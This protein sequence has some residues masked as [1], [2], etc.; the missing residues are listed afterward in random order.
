MSAE[1][2]SLW[3]PWRRILAC[4]V[5]AYVARPLVFL[6]L[7]LHCSSICLCHHVGF[8]LYEDANHSEL[9]PPLM[10]ATLTWVNLQ[11]PFFQIR[12]YLQILEVRTSIY[13]F[14]ENRIQPVA[15]VIMKYT[16]NIQGKGLLFKRKE[17]SRALTK[18][19]KENS[20]RLR[21]FGASASPR[22]KTIKHVQQE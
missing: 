18:L 9:R 16:Q 11:R 10:I 22:G 17:F 1:S 20:F 2:C 6:G 12:P 5:L 19:R 15:V 13:L 8:S 4:F 14:R 3:N 21:L 7:G